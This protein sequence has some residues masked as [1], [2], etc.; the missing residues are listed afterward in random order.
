MRES[1][2]MF[3]EDLEKRKKA[4]DN[5]RQAYERD[6]KQLIRHL[7]A[8][9]VDKPESVTAGT[10]QD[11]VLSM[12]ES[13]RAPSS[14]SRSMASIRAFFQ[15]LAKERKIKTNPAKGLH[16]PKPDREPPVVMTVEEVD[17][18]LRQPDE[19]QNIGLRDRA[20]LEVLYATG[21][22]VSEVIGLRIGDVEVGCGCIR[23]RGTGKERTLPLTENAGRAL[24]AY[25]ET[26]R[27]DMLRQSDEEALFVN[28]NGEPISRQGFWKMV[29]RHAE[30]AGINRRITPHVLRH[31]VAAHLLARGADMRMVQKMLGH[32][33]I[34]TTLMYY[35]QVTESKE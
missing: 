14:I 18:L 15:F 3:L 33:D 25:L 10:I 29:L 16:N 7:E 22:R 13:G 1:L 26:A 12:R 30:K 20:M 21:L 35:R 19:S 11:Y 9:G 17:A 2:R 32:A 5:T 4:P 28:Y 31:S 34:S 24:K 27:G 23:C 6:L 8:E